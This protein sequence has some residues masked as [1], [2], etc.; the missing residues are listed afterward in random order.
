MRQSALKKCPLLRKVYLL[1]CIREF[2]IESNHVN[3]RNMGRLFVKAQTLFNTRE[4]IL[5]KNPANV[6]NVGRTLVT[7]K[8]TVCQ[9]FHIDTDIWYYPN[10][11]MVQNTTLP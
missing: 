7:D 9:R 6:K 2:L 3:V 11:M 1:L 5:V 4:H 10:E 8:L